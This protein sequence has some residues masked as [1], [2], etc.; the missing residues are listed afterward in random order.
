MAVPAT[1]LQA[2]PTFCVYAC[3]GRA[4]AHPFCVSWVCEVFRGVRERVQNSV[5]GFQVLR[6]RVQKSVR[7]CQVLRERLCACFCDGHF[8]MRGFVVSSERV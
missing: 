5:R 6:E 3:V 7:G 1:S 4:R 8:R 2:P